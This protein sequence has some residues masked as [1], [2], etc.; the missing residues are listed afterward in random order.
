MISFI[1]RPEFRGT[2]RIAQKQYVI[3]LSARLRGQ[4]VAEYLG[5]KF[6]PPKPEG[7]CV[8]IKPRHLQP[9]KDGDYVDV[10]DDLDVIPFLKER[11]K[12]KVIAMSQ[13]HYEYLKR[14]LPNE[15]IL[16]YHH[17]INFERKRHTRNKKLVGGFIGAPSK[18]AYEKY[19]EIKEAL[20]KVGIDFTYC[21]HFQTRE[22]MVNYYMSI[23]FL[24]IYNLNLDDKNCFYRHPTKIINA[25]SF[26]IPSLAQPILGYKEIGGF[27]IPI[28]SVDDIVREVEKLKDLDYYSQFSNKICKEADKYHISNTT[29]LYKKL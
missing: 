25:A 1:S 18:V 29:K 27:Y 3:R 21:F 28:E 16:I 4:E 13:V 19:N 12:V 9:V 24:I 17:H 14:E 2:D 5:A 6:N 7:T 20:A 11:P 15:A 8:W 23:D 22:E 26:G 10:L